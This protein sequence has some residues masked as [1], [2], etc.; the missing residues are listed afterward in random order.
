[1]RVAGANVEH[2]G[3]ALPFGATDD[4]WLGECGERN[5]IVLTRDTNIRRRRLE[6]EALMASGVAAFALTS[7]EATAEEVADTIVPLVRKFVNMSV[8]EQKPFLYTF[9]LKGW[10]TKVRLRP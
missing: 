2:A 4:L 3:G 6:R 9:G 5:W 1:M 10:L 7:G 8:S